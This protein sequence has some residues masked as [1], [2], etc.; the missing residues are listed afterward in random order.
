MFLGIQK[1]SRGAEGKNKK[2]PDPFIHGGGET[3]LGRMVKRLRL[4]PPCGPEAGRRKPGE[5]N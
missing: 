4:I 5:E 3:W 2:T 1:N